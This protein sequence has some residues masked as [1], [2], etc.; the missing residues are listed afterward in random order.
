MS[1]KNITPQDDEFERDEFDERESFDEPEEE[2]RYDDEYDDRY[3]DDGY[4]DDGYDD[5][6]DDEEQLSER[7]RASIRRKNA[8][9]AGRQFRRRITEA[10][11]Q[12][13]KEPLL[14]P[15]VKGIIGIL[16]SL[17]FVAIVIMLFAKVLFMHEPNQQAKTGTITVTAA[18]GTTP[19]TTTGLNQ[20]QSRTTKETIKYNNNAKDSETGTSKKESAVTKIKCISAVLVH[21]EPNSSSAN[22]TTVPYG[23]EVD[24]IKDENGWYLI[25][26]Q[27]ITGYA[28]GQ[29]FDK[30]QIAADQN[31]DD[32]DF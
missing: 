26:Y 18:T 27:G 8:R 1:E 22:L 31:T 23:A 3:D 20:R 19:V 32:Y 15:T 2:N 30:P 4:D 28:W 17:I 16:I 24:F 5:G 9:D 10:D 14:S 29:F 12:E 25:T 6:Y 13:E 11:E 21:P 7:E